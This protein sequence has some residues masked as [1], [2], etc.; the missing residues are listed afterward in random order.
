MQENEKKDEWSG[1]SDGDLVDA[2]QD[3]PPPPFGS[4]TLQRKVVEVPRPAKERNNQRSEQPNKP[5]PKISAAYG[6]LPEF[7]DQVRSRSREKQHRHHRGEN[8]DLSP[9]DGV[10]PE[11]KDQVRYRSR[12]QFHRHH[13]GDLS[14]A[15]GVPPE[16]KDQARICSREQQHRHRR[17]EN[18][19]L[20][21]P[22][23]VVAVPMEPLESTVTVVDQTD[24]IAEGRDG[25]TSNVVFASTARIL[26]EEE[27]RAKKRKIFKL[28]FLLL[29]LFFAAVI[30]GGVCGGW[31]CGQKRSGE[32]D[33]GTF[34]PITVLPSL[35]PATASIVDYINNVTLAGSLIAYPAP[36]SATPEELALQWIIDEVSVP[37]STSSIALQ[38]RLE[39]LYALA[40]LWFYTDGENW[41]YSYDWLVADDVCTWYG[42]QCDQNGRVTELVFQGNGLHGS[43]PNDLGLLRNLEGLVM[44][45]DQIQGSIPS[46]LG[47]CTSLT[48]LSL[49]SNE[50]IGTLPESM[51]HLS[52][53]EFVQMSYNHLSGTLPTSL[54]QW[55]NI[56]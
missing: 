38:H 19:D 23:S 54:S 25:T 12:E 35:D 4:D 14:P 2:P 39:E 9:A 7:K 51:M 15:D 42:V 37:H 13:R 30:V 53:F 28:V 48:S 20:S 47:H 43:M 41:I 36:D 11:F 46:S 52:N 55:S 56:M 49:F 17:G 24:D 34:D 32:D 1:L 22:Q 21:T 3:Q 10:P 31:T 16:F 29:A 50:L 26:D 27:N 44:I 33:N 18:P 45:V 6:V 5:S 8:P 40:T